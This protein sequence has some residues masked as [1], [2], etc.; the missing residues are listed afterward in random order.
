MIFDLSPLTHK[1]Q[2]LL[3]EQDVQLKRDSWVRFSSLWPADDKTGWCSG[4]TFT[5]SADPILVDYPVSR[6]IVNGNYATLD[7]TND[8]NPTIPG[9]PHP[10]A[11]QAGTLQM[12]PATTYILY[13]IS[14]GIKPGK[15][16]LQI[17]FN[18]VQNPPVYQLGSAAIQGGIADPVYRYLGA[19]YPDDSPAN[20]P[21]LQLFTI[22]QAPKI[23]LQ[24][25]MDGGDTM[26]GGLLYGKGTCLFRVN[27]CK[28]AQVTRESLS[29]I[30]IPVPSNSQIL[31][32]SG[33][34]GVLTGGT[35]NN[36]YAKNTGGA[37]IPV[38]SGVS[39][40]FDPGYTLVTGSGY[41]MIT[42]ESDMRK[43]QGVQEK[44]LYLPYYTEL[45]NY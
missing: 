33:R 24:M 7:L 3:K 31:V 9:V 23:I 1:G 34:V 16:F 5:V 35:G 8:T 29:L 6:N 15:Q 28:L 17:Y 44:A 14:V 22:M 12:Y 26:V 40:M 41:G 30:N 27:K 32:P 4:K 42:T 2:M 20:F 25:Y 38:A 13:Q 11:A 36:T 45:T 18:S 19:K 21:T 39:M 43:W 10:T 37:T